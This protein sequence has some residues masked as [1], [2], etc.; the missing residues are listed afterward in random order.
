M[1]VKRYDF[2]FFFFFNIRRNE[3]LISKMEELKFFGEGIFLD[4]IFKVKKRKKIVRGI[5]MNSMNHR[6]NL[7]NERLNGAAVNK[8]S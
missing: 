8:S 7:H 1:L 6:S 4:N 2:T 3:G 5:S